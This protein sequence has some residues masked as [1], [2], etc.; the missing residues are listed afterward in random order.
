MEAIIYRALR[1]ATGRLEGQR[2]SVSQFGDPDRWNEASLLLM[3]K[4]DISKHHPVAS[5]SS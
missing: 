1:N 2:V 5:G 3:S 4:S